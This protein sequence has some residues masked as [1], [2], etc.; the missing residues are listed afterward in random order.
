MGWVGA[1]GGSVRHALAATLARL[2]SAFPPARPDEASGHPGR[3][4]VFSALKPRTK[5]EEEGGSSHRTL[6]ANFA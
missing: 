3:S 5:N 2:P 1:L 6:L 4:K